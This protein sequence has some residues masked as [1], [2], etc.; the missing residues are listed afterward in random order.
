ML[1]H[2]RAQ[3]RSVASGFLTVCTVSMLLHL[4]QGPRMPHLVCLLHHRGSPKL[5]LLGPMLLFVLRMVYALS[6]ASRVTLLRI[7][8]QLR[9]SWD[10]LAMAVEMV[11]ATVRPA[12]IILGLQTM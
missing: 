3:H 11:V 6:A 9:I 12:T 2:L 8:V 4:R 10:F 5:K 7:A 1:A